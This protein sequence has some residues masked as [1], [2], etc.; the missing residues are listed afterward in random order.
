MSTEDKIP[1]IEIFGPVLQGEGVVIGQPTWFVRTGG[2]DYRCLYCDSMHAVDGQ[3]IER[4]KRVMSA[5][6]IAEELLPQMGACEMVTLSG[7]NPALWDLRAFVL[8]TRRAGK[9]VAIET[10][11]SIWK[12]WIAF[13]DVI[14]LSPKGPGMI[15]NWLLALGGFWSFLRNLRFHLPEALFGRVNV[16]IPVFS[17]DDLDF[18]SRVRVGLDDRGFGG[19]RMTLSVG[20]LRVPKPAPRGT[21]QKP[22]PQL[23]LADLESM[24][25]AVFREYPL[26]MGCAI[27]PQ[28]H[29]LM[30]GN[31]EGK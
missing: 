17:R 11:A 19:V 26:L 7:G 25:R 23:L 9:R 28:L 5:Q 24:S 3:A 1:V 30:F 27:L 20:N 16:K 8:T 12:D 21:D 10:Q 22:E 18:A 2:C 14:T 13:C 31:Q 15:D 29:V 4:R 6:E